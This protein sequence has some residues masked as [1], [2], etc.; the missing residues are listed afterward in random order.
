MFAAIRFAAILAV[1]GAC[2]TPAFAAVPMWKINPQKSRL[3]W[4]VYYDHETIKG[5]FIN[6]DG[7]IHFDPDHLEQSHFTITIDLASVVSNSKKIEEA[8]L[9]PYFFNTAKFP[10]AVYKSGQIR[11]T[12]QGYVA[13]GTLTLAGVSKRLALPFKVV[14]NDNQEASA[15]SHFSL[16]RHAFNVGHGPADGANIGDR[17][18]INFTLDAVRQN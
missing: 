7:D 2:V 5:D 16:S 14:I 6:W 9:G 1:F 11:A 12:S 4:M 10:K 17:V 13:A 8:L 3:S 15:E 18:D